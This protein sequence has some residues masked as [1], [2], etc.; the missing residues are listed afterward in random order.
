MCMGDEN[1]DQAETER[2]QKVIAVT[3]EMVSHVF[4]KAIAYVNVIIIAGYIAF[5]ALWNSTKQ[6]LPSPWLWVSAGLITVSVLIFITFE[7]YKMVLTDKGIRS[8]MD[9]IKMPPPDVNTLQLKLQEIEFDM[10]A[11]LSR[12]QSFVIY[13]TVSTGLGAGLILGCMFF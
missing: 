1:H 3:K 9:V 12:V 13:S 11:K 2:V 4:G 8:Q 5:F 7:I 6:F 10:T